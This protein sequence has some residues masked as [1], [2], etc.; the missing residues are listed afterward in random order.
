MHITILF[1][2]IYFIAPGKD[3]QPRPAANWTICLL[4]FDT[5]AVFDY[6]KA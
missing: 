4:L 5:D 1:P 2:C 3:C 6:Y